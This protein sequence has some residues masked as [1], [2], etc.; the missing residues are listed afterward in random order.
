MT[1]VQPTKK[2]FTSLNQTISKFYWENKNP[3][4]SLQKL[5][6]NKAQG[7]LAA[8]NFLHYYS[9]SHLQYLCKW[10]RYDTTQNPWLELEQAECKDIAISDLPSLTKK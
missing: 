1:P 5:Q 9:A 6:K 4:I 10:I 7:G 2:W 3:K 8:P